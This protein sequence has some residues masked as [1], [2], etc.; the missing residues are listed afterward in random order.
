MRPDSLSGALADYLLSLRESDPS[1]F[2]PL[3][4]RLRSDPDYAAAFA[5]EVSSTLFASGFF[6]A[7]ESLLPAARDQA[8]SLVETLLERAPSDDPALALMREIVLSADDPAFAS[9]LPD[10]DRLERAL[11]SRRSFLERYR[12]ARSASPSRAP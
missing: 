8:R 1:A 4:E 10:P 7:A 12:L 3:A 6:L 2:A 5:Q 11:A 9:A